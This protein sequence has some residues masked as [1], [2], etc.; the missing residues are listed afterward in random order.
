MLREAMARNA[1]VVIYRQPEYWF[2]KVP[3]LASYKHKTV[4]PNTTQRVWITPGNLKNGYDE[5]L[6]R[7][8]SDQ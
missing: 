3:E 8:R 1:F 7:V 2:E 4:D 5:I 6:K